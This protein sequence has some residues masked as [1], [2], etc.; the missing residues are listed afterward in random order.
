MYLAGVNEID[1]KSDPGPGPGHGQDPKLQPGI[2]EKA[3]AGEDPRTGPR[4]GR[5]KLPD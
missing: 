5:P 1:Q 2:I 3:E 4:A